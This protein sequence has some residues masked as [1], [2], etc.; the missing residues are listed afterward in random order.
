MYSLSNQKSAGR[1]SH[2]HES[3]RRASRRLDREEILALLRERGGWVPLAEIT[4]RCAQARS[5]LHELKMQGL[6]IVSIETRDG[7]FYLLDEQVAR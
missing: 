5:R 4:A 3:T 1:T 6:P 2:Q 7:V